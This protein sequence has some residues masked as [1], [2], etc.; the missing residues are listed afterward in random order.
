MAKKG[1]MIDYLLCT[2]CHSCEVSCKLEKKLS[3]GAYGIKLAEDAPWQIDEDTWEYKWLPVPTQLCDL[4]ED[5][6]A[7]GKEP[8]CVVHCCSHCMHYG[9][10][11]EL[12]KKMDELDRKA[13]LY[14]I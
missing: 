2:G 7:E 8:S 5:R 9:D 4:C 12:A 14:T 6:T 13:V 1:L 3:T 11:D 10:L